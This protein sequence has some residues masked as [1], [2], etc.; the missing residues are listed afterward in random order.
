MT[1]KTHVYGMSHPGM[2][3][4]KN[5]DYFLINKDIGLYIICDGVGGHQSGQV[6]SEQCAKAIEEYLFNKKQIIENYNKNPS[7]NDRKIV[8]SLLEHA[9]QYANTK[10]NDLTESDVLIKKMCTTVVVLLVT[11]DYAFVAHV[12]DSRA[13]L[14]RSNTIHQLTEDHKVLVQMKK[15]G[16][17][18]DE[19]IHNHPNAHT[20]TRAVGVQNYVQ[21][22]L[23]EM[24]LMNKD[25]FVL[26]TDGLTDNIKT[27]EIL[28]FFDKSELSTLP[29]ALINL[30]NARGGHD[31][32]TTIAL[33]V[34]TKEL[35]PEALNALRKTQ[36]FGKVPLF[37]Y[38]NYPELI[39]V[40]NIAKVESYSA[41]HMLFEEGAVGNKMFIILNGKVQVVK[42]GQVISKRDRGE[43]IG[44]MA[45]F[46]NAKRSAA[47]KC[48]EL[49]SFLVVSKDDLFPFLKYEKD[50]AVKI[51]WALTLELMQR[52]RKTSEELAETKTD[53]PFLNIEL[54]NK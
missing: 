49:T 36:L 10:I 28:G 52:L 51:L 41:N 24:E 12:G 27:P 40:L 14:I 4:E 34:E 32:I 6:A 54:E 15:Q 31:N 7:V 35:A 39:K 42:S 2:K 43:V 20:L 37:R 45:L 1:M 9:V 21:V 19:Q 5:E 44:E 46:D 48:S 23:F 26:C 53:I 3:R 13:Y 33:C 16:L 8:S 30:S 22:D 38:L 17:L 11:Q 29:Q 50:I 47:I 25:Q 18:T